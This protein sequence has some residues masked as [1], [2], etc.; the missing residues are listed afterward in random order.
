MQEVPL[1]LGYVEDLGFYSTRSQFGQ[2]TK[3]KALQKG[4]NFSN[5]KILFFSLQFLHL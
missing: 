2:G 1:Y 3:A 4:R 5:V